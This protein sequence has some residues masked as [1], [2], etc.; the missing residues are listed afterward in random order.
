LKPLTTAHVELDYAALMVSKDMLRRWSGTQW[1]E[2]DFTL[3]DNRKDLERH[4]REHQERVAFTFTVMNPAETECLGCVYINPLENVIRR[5][6]ATAELPAVKDY[7]AT[8]AFWAKQPRLA[9]ELDQRLFDALRAWLQRDW[10][11]SHVYFM[12]NNRDL[13]QVDL[14][15]RGG[16][17]LYCTLERSGRDGKQAIYH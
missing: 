5:A 14:F 12:T 17:Q 2:D 7:E 6:N 15:T 1:P 3:A 11:F 4:Q 9:D 16:L 8:I 13:R 10:A